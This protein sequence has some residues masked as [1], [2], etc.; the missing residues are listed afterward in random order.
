MLAGPGT[1]EVSGKPAEAVADNSAPAVVCSWESVVPGMA[2]EAAAANNSESVVVV[3]NLKPAA[4]YMVVRNLKPA[5]AYMALRLLVAALGISAQIHL[6][7]RL[8]EY[9]K[10]AVSSG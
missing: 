2:V 6:R 5:A 1:A 9:Q 7:A 4:A 8:G 3:R 10:T